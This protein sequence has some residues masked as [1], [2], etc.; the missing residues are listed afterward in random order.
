MK[1]IS[2]NKTRENHT[3]KANSLL[4][5]YCS[6]F[7]FHP[8][9]PHGLYSP[10]NSPGQSTEVGTESPGY[11]PNPGIEQGLPH[12]RQIHYQLS[13]EGRPSFTRKMV[14]NN[15]FSGQQWR[16]RHTE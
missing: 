15:L 7:F 12:H 10:W 11:F 1:L 2:Q 6:L 8:F 5:K 16:N 3:S 4:L 13:Y 14:L 9:Q